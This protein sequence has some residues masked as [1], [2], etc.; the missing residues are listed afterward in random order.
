MLVQNSTST[1]TS[2]STSNAPAAFSTALEKQGLAKE[3]HTYALIIIRRENN[4]RRTFDSIVGEYVFELT[5]MGLGNNQKL[6]LKTRGLY[7]NIEQVHAIGTLTIRRGHGVI[8]R[9]NMCRLRSG[10]NLR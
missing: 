8:D 2:T 9:V 3:A 4:P 7:H 10:F 6:G 1:S 5:K